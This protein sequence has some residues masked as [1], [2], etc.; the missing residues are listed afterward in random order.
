MSETPMKKQALLIG[1]NDYQ[2]LPGLKYAR[3]DAE[4][5]SAVYERGIPGI[6]TVRHGGTPCIYLKEYYAS[7]AYAASKL[8]LIDQVCLKEHIQDTD[9]LISLIEAE[10]GIVYAKAQRKAINYALANGVMVLTG[11]PGTGRP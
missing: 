9:R 3:Q 5:V 10:E 1:I 2:I 6:I 7:E 8:V 4:A 11:G